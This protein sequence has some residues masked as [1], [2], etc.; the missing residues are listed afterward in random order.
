[1]NNTLN[2]VLTPKGEEKLLNYYKQMSK[3]SA[4]LGTNYLINLEEVLKSR[5]NV[6][7]SYNLTIEELINIFFLESEYFISICQNKVKIKKL[8]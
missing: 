5:K 3:L 7:K 8:L 6:D 4:Y 1:M 2:V